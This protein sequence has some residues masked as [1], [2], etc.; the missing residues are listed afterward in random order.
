MQCD[1]LHVFEVLDSNTK[2]IEEKRARCGLKFNLRTIEFKHPDYRELTVEYQLC[3]THYA[4]VFGV[5]ETLENESLRYAKNCQS[6]YNQDFAKAKNVSMA[7]IG[8]FN[9]KE[10]KILNYR[11]VENAYDAWRV[12]KKEKCRYELCSI[13]LK[14]IRKVFM[15]RVYTQSGREWKNYLF[16][17]KDHWDVFR[18]RMIPKSKLEVKKQSLTLDNF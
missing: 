17:S 1:Y 7:G 12:I 14:T 4:E 5:I 6:A 16:C 9:T 8:F 3:Q 18:Y 10:Y 11:K 15:I 2:K 13:N